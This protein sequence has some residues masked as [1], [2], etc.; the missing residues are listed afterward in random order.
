MSEAVLVFDN[1]SGMSRAGFAGDENPYLMF[2]YGKA[3]DGIGQKHTYVGDEAEIMSDL[4]MSP[5][6]PHPI[7]RGIVTNWDDMEKIWQYSFDEL[8]AIPEERAILLGDSPFNP[9]PNREK[10][11][12]IMFETFNTHALFI[13]VQAVLALFSY[14]DVTGIVLD[15]GEGV[16]NVVPIYQGHVIPYG[17]QRLELGG[18]DLDN[19]LLQMLTE[20]GHP[21]D[22][23]T[24]RDVVRN[25]KESLSY[26]ALDFDQ[27][28]DSIN[29]YAA[30]EKTYTLPDGHPFSNTTFRV[31]CPEALFQPFLLG[32]DQPGVHEMIH[33]AIEKCDVDI[34]TDLYKNVVLSGGSTMFPGIADRLHKELLMFAP[35]G[36]RVKVGAGPD[37]FH[38]AWIGGSMLASLSG[39]PSMWLSKE[40]YNESGP[41]VVHRV[42][43]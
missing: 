37:R 39:F 35:S 31:R 43:I 11:S 18:R 10:M 28:L 26:V 29:A 3:K 7:E 23:P 40:E 32:L 8:H 4:R 27:E 24:Q 1:G 34:R 42:C 38:A 41:S 12:Q 6:V 25:I 13:A 17:I 36:V 5:N 16:T 14:S 22:A 20:Q 15:S 19:F 21:F 2:P 33:S 9:K 30:V